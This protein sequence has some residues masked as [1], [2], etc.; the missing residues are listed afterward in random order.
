MTPEEW[1]VTLAKGAEAQFRKNYAEQLN[2]TPDTMRQQIERGL[3]NSARFVALG[4]KL[5]EAVDQAI[6]KNNPA[7][8]V[9]RLGLG[10]T[11]HGCISRVRPKNALAQAAH[12]E[13]PGKYPGIPCD[14]ASVRRLVSQWYT[15]QFYTNSDWHHCF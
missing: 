8:K 6:A 14:V 3:E 1:R 15:V 2:W 5:D 13:R 9:G 12:T 7:F 4:D 11:K 10:W